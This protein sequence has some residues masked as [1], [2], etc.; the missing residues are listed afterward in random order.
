MAETTLPLSS[1][2]ARLQSRLTYAQGIVARHEAQ[3]GQKW[4]DL[5]REGDGSMQEEAEQ[6]Q[7]ETDQRDSWKPKQ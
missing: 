4:A 7:A 2:Q 5:L 6:D 1:D 3:I